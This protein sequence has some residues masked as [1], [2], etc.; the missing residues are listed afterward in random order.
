MS[1]KEV[2]SN[3]IKQKI[4]GTSYTFRGYID[5]LISVEKCIL[6][7]PTQWAEA[8]RQHD[9]RDKYSKEWH[10]IEKELKPWKYE[11]TKEDEPEDE[12]IY[13]PREVEKEEEE[14]RKAWS[15]LGGVE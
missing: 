15:E 12:L 7:P 9:I 2:R 5:R 14:N 13:N 3:Y 4:K 10:T 6:N 1:Y 8:M 11:E